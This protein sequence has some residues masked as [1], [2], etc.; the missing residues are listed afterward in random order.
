MMQSAHV[1]TTTNETLAGNY[2]AWGAECVHVIENYLPDYYRA[3]AP[4]APHEGL[5]IGWVAAA[6]HAHDYRQL[7]LKETLRRV[8]DRHP[9][10]R[11]VSIGIDLG[12]ARERYQH[13]QLVQYQELADE[14]AQFDIGLA[15]I[16]DIPFNR[17]RSNVKVKEYAAVGVPWLASPIGPYAGL[18][19]KQG[20]RLVPDDGW[21]AALER[22]ITSPRERAKLA[23]RGRKWAESQRTR[24]NVKAWE[25]A[26]QEAAA[27]ARGG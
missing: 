10:V 4:P 19:E 8:L 9:H 26:V 23:K 2:R 12:L 11:V 14:V 24:A 15:P 18:G 6:E 13:R 16:I 7:E 20:G 5:V 27:R 22:L 25:R 21:E 1:V 3:A 17:A